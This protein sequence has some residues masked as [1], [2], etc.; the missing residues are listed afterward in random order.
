MKR[1][2][3]KENANKITT[4]QEAI[5]QGIL[6][7]VPDFILKFVGIK[8][9]TGVTNKVLEKVDVYHLSRLVSLLQTMALKVVESDIHERIMPFSFDGED[10]LCLC[11]PGD[12][13]N[14][15]VFT[16]IKLKLNFDELEEEDG[17][18]IL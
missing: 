5:D 16:I 13:G 18:G 9:P 11:G 17:N 15:H 7:D 2:D 8:V 3:G 6:F 10:Y 14:G 12:D 4:R 1:N